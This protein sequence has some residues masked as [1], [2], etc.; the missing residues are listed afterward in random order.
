MR[1][2]REK[3]SN[4]VG[5]CEQARSICAS[6]V[7]LDSISDKVEGRNALLVTGGYGSPDAFAPLPPCLA[8]RALRDVPINDHIS[9]RLFGQVVRRFDSRRRDKPEIACAIFTQ[10]L[11]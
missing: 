8:P 5:R 3:S 11:G 6:E 2:S 1:V 4:S 10:A 9:D 7:G